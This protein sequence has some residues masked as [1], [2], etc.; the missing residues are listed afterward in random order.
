MKIRVAVTA[1]FLTLC[2]FMSANAST[3]EAET[4]VQETI[5]QVLNRLSEKREDLDAHPEHI[6]GVID[7]L[8]A[9]HFDFPIMSRWILGK[10]WAKT[11]VDKQQAFI[12]QF[13]TLLVRTYGKALMEYSGQSISFLPL[14][15]NPNSNLVI[16]KTEVTSEGS[17][18]NITMN[19]RM[20][21]S[22]GKWKVIDIS[23]DGVSLVGTYRGSF[24]SEIRKNG[25]DSL[26]QKLTERNN[27]SIGFEEG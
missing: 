24:G 13:K 14:E 3:Q 19:Y 5:D 23:I 10:I 1:L 20:H 27:K 9:P 6:Y 22:G 15:S 12:E 25:I 8:V 21:T 2:L 18:S 4:V 11:P 7:E 17:S 16:V 26:I